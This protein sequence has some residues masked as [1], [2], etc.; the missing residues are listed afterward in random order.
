MNTYEDGDLCVYVG[1]SLINDNIVFAKMFSELETTHDISDYILY[2]G[3]SINV[4]I[5]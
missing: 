1:G 4:N 5:S 3:G 2:F